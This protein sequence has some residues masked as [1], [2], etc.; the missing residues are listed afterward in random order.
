MGEI[1]DQLLQINAFEA[2]S[3]AAVVLNGLGFDEEAQNMPLETFSGDFRMRIA[4][5]SVLYQ[6]PDLFLLDEPTNHLD[7]E[8]T[9]WL[10]DF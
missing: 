4:L 8:T 2:E 7:L 6:E 9:D 3:R 1:Y 5:G 10:K